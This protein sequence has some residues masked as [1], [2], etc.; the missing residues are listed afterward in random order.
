M[1]SSDTGLV[2]GQ[3]YVG[4][5][6][7]WIKSRRT[8]D[9]VVRLG[10]TPSGLAGPASGQRAYAAGRKRLLQIADVGRNRFNLRLRQAVRN[11]LH[12]S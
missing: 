1:R 4:K 3:S 5:A 6:R 11:R 8:A 9:V 12:N 7:F 2:I 10:L